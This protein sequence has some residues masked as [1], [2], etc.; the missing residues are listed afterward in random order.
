[1]KTFEIRE[2]YVNSIER[3][4]TLWLGKNEYNF[5]FILDGL[6]Y[7]VSDQ[8][9]TRVFGIL[10]GLKD[11]GKN[12]K[13]EIVVIPSHN[14][15]MFKVCVINSTN[16]KYVQLCEVAADTL[17]EG[18]ISYTMSLNNISYCTITVN[19]AYEHSI[20]IDKPLLTKLLSPRRLN[21]SKALND[22]YISLE[23]S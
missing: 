3:Q 19:G 2:G 20:E 9:K 22:I 4:S 6:N 10:H 1:M 14:P 7:N 13:I 18:S 23:V 11:N 15:N 8:V 17:V 12:K 16:S 21:S 5:A